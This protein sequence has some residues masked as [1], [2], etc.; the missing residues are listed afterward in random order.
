[1]RGRVSYFLLAMVQRTLE[2]WLWEVQSSLPI[3]D[4]T[5]I[6][7]MMQCIV[8]ESPGV[9]WS[10]KFHYDVLYLETVKSTIYN[11]TA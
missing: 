9:I 1:M 5:A 11:E 7:V 6:S 10:F 4:L 3:G 8:S 2:K